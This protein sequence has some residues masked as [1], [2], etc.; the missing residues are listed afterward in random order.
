MCAADESL[1]GAGPL[2]TAP[3]SA[4]EARRAMKA[5]DLL[6]STS[7]TDSLL[8]L[9]LVERAMPRIADRIA[10]RRAE[11]LLQLHRPDEACDAYRISADSVERDVATAGRIGLVRCLL[12]GNK[13]QGEAELSALCKRYPRLGARF[14]LRLALARARETWHDR[15]GAMALYRSIDLEAPE[16]VAAAEARTALDALREQGIHV[17][18][19]TPLE[20]VDHAE[21]LFLRGSVEAGR[22]AIADL[23]T[24]N[25]L[26]NALKGRAHLMAARA[27]RLEG[28]YDDTRE[29]VARAIAVGVSAGEANRFLPRASASP[30]ATDPSIGQLKVRK[31]LA[32]RSIA[33]L[34]PG[35]LRPVL[36]LAVQYG[37]SDV[38]SE[39]LAAINNKVA[40]P[41]QARFD[42]AIRGVGIASDET[43][44]AT[45]EGL[46]DTW[47]FQTSA[48]YYHAR[49]LERLGRDAEARNEY[50]LVIDI[51]TGATHYY[52]VWAQARLSGYEQLAA[53]SC[54]RDPN[55]NCLPDTGLQLPAAASIQ[56]ADADARLFN[57]QP[58]GLGV[59]F[60]EPEHDAFGMPELKLDAPGLNGARDALDPNRRVLG[61]NTRGALGTSGALDLRNARRDAGD[62]K[63]ENIVTRLGALA[64]VYGAA[65]PWI[66][67]AADLA[68]L[69]RYDDAAAE[70]AEAYEAYR[71]ARGN[72]RF[73]A[74]IEAVLTNQA[75]ARRVCTRQVQRDRSSLDEA[76]RYALADVSDLLGDPGVALRLR[77]LRVDPFP[78]AYEGDVEKAAA[79]FGID[80][81]LLFAVMKVESVY[82]RNIVSFAG[83]VGLMQIMPLTGLRIARALGHRDYDALELLEP[84][85]NVEFAAWYLSSLITRFDG[86]LPLA[87]AAYNGGPHN[88]RYWVAAHPANMPLDAFLERIPFHE[89]HN[90]V[91]RVLANYA[92]Y[93]AQQNLPMTNLAISLPTIK[94]DTIAF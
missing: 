68:E 57:L 33:R 21:R 14:S 69:E 4:D 32:G 30:E 34:K 7:P 43:V 36:D 76:A 42:A 82:Y 80:P 66:G 63:R 12:E 24:M 53:G 67:R 47:G 23:L 52:S 54:P 27:A 39:A 11:L 83:A 19:M 86:R 44:L 64:S 1:E 25:N 31:Y 29:E 65:F 45:F 26:P 61:A 81:N 85:N 90:Y 50:R 6:A 91:R 28:R 3:I 77:S 10:L 88:V 13:R 92:A 51:D 55:G 41:P 70:I 8:Q 59:V 15:L 2:W 89:T 20:I 58:T 35:Q 71:D 56:G 87:I 18:P 79:K 62:V 16:T 40:Q 75:P 49:A 93:R 74:G 37:L 73:R 72:L 46:R 78:R 9:R 60:A 48:T 5:A 17:P 84:R 38:A 22:S 94:T